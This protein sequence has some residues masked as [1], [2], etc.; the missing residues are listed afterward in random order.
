MTVS[1]YERCQHKPDS[2]CMC[3]PCTGCSFR[4]V[5][6]SANVLGVVALLSLFTG[7]TYE[8]ESTANSG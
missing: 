2:V 5:H 1:T 6:G 8:T 7:V 4:Y 3:S